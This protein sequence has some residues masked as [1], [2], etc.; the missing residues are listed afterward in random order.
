MK[1]LLGDILFK[2][3]TQIKLFALSNGLHLSEDEVC[4][5]RVASLIFVG[6][7]RISGLLH[8]IKVNANIAITELAKIVSFY[9]NKAYL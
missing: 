6:R 9:L 4:E 8:C 5:F 3:L 1:I 2:Q 7:A